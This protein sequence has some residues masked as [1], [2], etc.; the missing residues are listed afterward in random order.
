M[1]PCE[2][3]YSLTFDIWGKTNTHER[4]HVSVVPTNTPLCEVFLVLNRTLDN[5]FVVF[6]SL[7][8]ALPRLETDEV[9]VSPFG[10]DQ[11]QSSS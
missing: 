5:L 7:S 1:S 6:C 8:D 3:V 2:I 4:K 11:H 10:Q 9:I